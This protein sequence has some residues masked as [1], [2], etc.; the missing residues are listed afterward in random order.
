[1]K[2]LKFGGSSIGNAERIR[3][4]RKIIESQSP[5]IVVV[6]AIENVTDRLWDIC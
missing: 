1:M 4:A 2:V 6:S 5:C 3:E